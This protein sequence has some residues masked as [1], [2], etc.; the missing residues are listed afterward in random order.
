M[1][2]KLT[3]YD[4]LGY[5]KDPEPQYIIRLDCW[6]ALKK[7]NSQHK[8]L[9]ILKFFEGQSNQSI[10][11]MTGRKSANSIASTICQ[12]LKKLRTE[13]GPVLSS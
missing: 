8:R 5:R 6:R 2:R 9:I 3:I 7:L 13:L 11:D 1:N 10:A 4:F 12:L